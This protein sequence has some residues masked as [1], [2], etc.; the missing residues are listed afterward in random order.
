ISGSI[1][2]LEAAL[3]MLRS[4]PEKAEESIRKSVECLRNGV[5][6]IRMSLREERPQKL[7]LGIGQI[8][9]MLK[10]FE[11]TYNISTQFTCDKQPD[12][13]ST[14]IWQCIIENLEESLTNMLK[15]SNG[16]LFCVNI[17]K[18]KQILKVEFSD[19]G[20]CAGE[21]EKGIGLDAIEER[22]VKSGGRCLISCGHNGFSIKLIF[23]IPQ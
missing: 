13:I 1:L 14:E 17:E 8:T 16:D 18:Y 3:M 21:Y 15:H 5:D 20:K 10:E 7:F 11:L 6:E 12:G 2:M 19:N 23:N 4:N 9:S 22:T